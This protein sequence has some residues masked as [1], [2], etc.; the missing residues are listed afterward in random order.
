MDRGCCAVL[1]PIA[2]TL[3]WLSLG[4]SHSVRA[5]HA[6]RLLSMLAAVYSRASD[7]QQSKCLTFVWQIALYSA[8]SLFHLM[9]W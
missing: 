4:L 3:M 9:L 7:Q 5:V 2:C 1:G 6:L 8:G